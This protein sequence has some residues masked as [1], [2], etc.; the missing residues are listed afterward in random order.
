MDATYQYLSG[1]I[2]SGDFA[3]FIYNY[4]NVYPN[5]CKFHEEDDQSAI[6]PFFWGTF[7]DRGRTFKPSGP[8]LVMVDSDSEL[9]ML[10]IR[11]EGCGFTSMFHNSRLFI[12]SLAQFTATIIYKSFIVIQCHYEIVRYTFQTIFLLTVLYNTFIFFIAMFY[13]RRVP[14][15]WSSKNTF[16]ILTMFAA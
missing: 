15:N 13:Y 1:I 3:R 4:S 8:S 11:C 6:S 9:E 2:I 16:Q 10:W 5:L 7:F 12:D 14:E